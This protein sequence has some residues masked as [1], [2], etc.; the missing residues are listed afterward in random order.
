M[1][2]V[3]YQ[4]GLTQPLPHTQHTADPG[5]LFGGH[6][7]VFYGNKPGQAVKKNI[8]VM[9][10]EISLSQLHGKERVLSS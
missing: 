3:P 9:P 10:S 5:V 6:R 8:V 2:M 1:R 4:P 7:R